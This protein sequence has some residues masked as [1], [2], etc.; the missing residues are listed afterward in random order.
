MVWCRGSGGDKIIIEKKT[1]SQR[2]SLNNTFANMP[3][4]SVCVGSRWR[5]GGKRKTY[6]LARLVICLG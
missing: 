3:S 1:S 6:D 5:S 4:N 2:S